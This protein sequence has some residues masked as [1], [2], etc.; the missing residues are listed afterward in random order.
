MDVRAQEK[1][2]KLLPLEYQAISGYFIKIIDFRFIVFGFYITAIG[3]LFSGAI[4]SYK[5]V[6][7]IILTVFIWLLEIRNRALANNLIER[8]IKIE[9][10]IYGEEIAIE[11]NMFFH[12]MRYGLGGKYQIYKPGGGGEAAHVFGVKIKNPLV[13]KS[14][15]YSAYLITHTFIFDLA[16]L[17]AIIWSFIGLLIN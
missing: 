15:E 10:N 11:E 14:K 3:L 1:S 16:Y 9:E 2:E 13:F 7:I 12:R 4:E 17:T 8:G 6:V 5:L